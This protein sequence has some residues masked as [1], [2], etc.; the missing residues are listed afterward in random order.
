M[1]EPLYRLVYVSRNRIDGGDE[2]LGHEVAEILDVARRLNASAGVTGAL[3]FNRRCFAQVLEGRLDDVQETFER[4]QCD[5]RH[6]RASILSFAPIERRDFADWSMAFV[7][8][9]TPSLET[10]NRLT[11]A[12]DFDPDSL[13]GDDV[14]ALVREHLAESDTASA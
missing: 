10:F 8:A 2:D 12:N 9:P 7:G 5:E 14:F 4:I 3:M 1:T 11:A 6:D 13:S